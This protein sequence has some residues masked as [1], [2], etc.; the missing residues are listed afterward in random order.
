MVKKM[1]QLVLREKRESKQQ[2]KKET[3][4]VCIRPNE[5]RGENPNLMTSRQLMVDR[6]AI[7]SR[8]QVK[9]EVKMEGETGGCDK[10]KTRWG[11]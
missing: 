11:K 2:R 5:K 7:D 4:R 9:S 8:E 1:N 3:E 10:V 6:L